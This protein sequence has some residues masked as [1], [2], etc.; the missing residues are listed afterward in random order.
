MTYCKQD[1]IKAM[2]ASIKA[3]RSSYKVRSRGQVLLL[4][5][6]K[7]YIYDEMFILT[8]LWYV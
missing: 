5:L 7:P 3:G 1:S 2:P 4:K 6:Q 8:S